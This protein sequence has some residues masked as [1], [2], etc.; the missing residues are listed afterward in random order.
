MAFIPVPNAVSVEMRFTQ[1][2][3]LVENTFGVITTDG[4]NPSTRLA[5]ATAFYNW[6]AAEMQTL[7]SSTVLL[8]EVYV[9]DITDEAGGTTAFIPSVT[10]GGANVNPPLP[11]GTTLAVSAR[12]NARGRSYR[13]RSYFIGLTENVV[14]HNRV[15]PAAVEAIQAAY[16]TLGPDYLEV[17][18]TLGVISRYANKNPRSVGVITPITGWVITDDVVDSQRRRLPGRGQ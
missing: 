7:V 18:G 9:T 4:D 10:T 17:N 3:Q 15:T 13:G 1:D 5:I 2:G 16:N 6:W 12:T 11:N 8:R 14:D